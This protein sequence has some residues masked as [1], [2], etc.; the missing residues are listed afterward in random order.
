MAARAPRGT[1]A[2][3][4]RHPRGDAHASTTG[5]SGRHGT[6]TPRPALDDVLP[7]QGAI[8][9]RTGGLPKPTPGRHTRGRHT[10]PRHGAY[11]TTPGAA[12]G[13]ATRDHATARTPRRPAAR[14]W[15]RERTARYAHSFAA[16]TAREHAKEDRARQPVE[17]CD[18]AL[19]VVPVVHHPASARGA[20]ALVLT[21]SMAT[22]SGARLLLLGGRFFL[23]LGIATL[24]PRLTLHGWWP[25]THIVGERAHGRP[26]TAVMP[27]RRGTAAPGTAA[28]CS[29]ALA[30]G[31]RALTART[32]NVH[33]ERA[34][35]QQTLSQL[36][37]GL[38][39]RIGISQRNE[40]EAATPAVL[41]DGQ[42]QLRDGTDPSLFENLG[43]LIFSAVT[44]EVGEE[45]SVLAIV[46]I[47]SRASFTRA[48]RWPRRHR[49]G[50]GRTIA[51]ERPHG[52]RPPLMQG[53]VELA[54][55]PFCLVF[56]GQRDETEAAS[57]ACLAIAGHGNFRHAC[58][59]SLKQLPQLGLIDGFGQAR[60]EE[61]ASIWIGHVSRRGGVR[62]R[63][64]L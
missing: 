47:S 8:V 22:V 35:A 30:A 55:S 50:A 49:A 54:A 33:R 60:N 21:A 39:R 34:A 52:D 24:V 45:E 61:L 57:S 5:P 63:R 4:R 37:H 16:F 6:N 13:H 10:R 40:A 9:R 43:Q 36:G 58:P 28:T 11:T 38:A 32:R 41:V 25:A 46:A 3:S 1:R 44:R 53:A 2:T 7:A 18:G 59:R 20:E 31:A 26:A 23:A 19:L 27:R 62:G 15:H 12:P 64:F 51:T 42:M 56:R 17:R 48:A 14:A 29:G